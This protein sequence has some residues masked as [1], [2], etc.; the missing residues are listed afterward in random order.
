MVAEDVGELAEQPRTKSGILAPDRPQS[1]LAE[2]LQRWPELGVADSLDHQ[3]C[4]GQEVHTSQRSRNPGRSVAALQA[5]REVAGTVLRISQVDQ[6]P[7]AA[8]LLR[9]S[10]K[11]TVQ[12]HPV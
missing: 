7:A 8:E 3:S 4:L 9:R 10:A 12:C 6:Q 11:E 1:V 2:P 5:Q